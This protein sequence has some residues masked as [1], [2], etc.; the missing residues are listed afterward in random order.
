[1][2]FSNE[3]KIGV[4][5]SIVV[6]S[7]IA[8]TIKAG[9]FNF[10]S[11]GYE[12]NVHFENI[13]GI[14]KNAPVMLNGF[15]VGVVKDIAII[16]D[17]QGT[18]MQLM[19]WLDEEAKLREGA[20]AYVKNMGFM[21]EK[22]VGLTSGDAGAPYLTP[23]SIITGEEPADLDKLLIDA[24]EIVDQVKS[25]ATNLNERLTVNQEAI[26]RIFG[27]LDSTMENM[28]SIT[29]NVDERLKVNQD[30][31]DEILVRLRSAAVN[32]D[33]FTYDLKLNPWKLLYRTKEER[34]KNRESRK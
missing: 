24:Q 27:N 21:G 30:N 18:R 25:V 1:M 9:D 12:I 5:V 6:V 26:D 32:M 4:M 17:E 29:D 2:K 14:D 15:E 13:D 23:G 8:L 28:V 31:I 20:R 34:K 33:E 3:V 22:Y 11:K 19:V 16:D 7:L 10:S